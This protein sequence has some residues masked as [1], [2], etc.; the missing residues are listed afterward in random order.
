M[1]GVGER[2]ERAEDIPRASSLGDGMNND[3]S[4]ELGSIE[5]ELV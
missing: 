2:E 1:T 3:P 5:K 4:I